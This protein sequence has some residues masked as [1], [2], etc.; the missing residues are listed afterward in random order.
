MTD[1]KRLEL[2]LNKSAALG[3]AQARYSLLLLVPS[4]QVLKLTFSRIKVL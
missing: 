1:E 3:K 4:W 2:A